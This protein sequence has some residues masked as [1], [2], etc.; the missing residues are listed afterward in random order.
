[1]NLE[2]TQEKLVNRAF[3]HYKAIDSVREAYTVNGAKQFTEYMANSCH[4]G[5][6]LE[7]TDV[8][9]VC[10]NVKSISGLS[11]EHALELE[12]IDKIEAD[13]DYREEFGKQITDKLIGYFE[14]A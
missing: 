3:E 4:H 2:T 8:W 11:D 6:I 10:K 7:L 13:R 9:A 14:K 5:D 12:I 1:M